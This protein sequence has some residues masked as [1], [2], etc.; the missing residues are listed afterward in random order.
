MTSS[1]QTLLVHVISFMYSGSGLGI[2]F[3]WEVGYSLRCH[4]KNA[5]YSPILR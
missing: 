4:F 3:G 1:A 2:D 5:D